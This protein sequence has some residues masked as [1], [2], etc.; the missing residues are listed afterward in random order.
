M[1]H[2]GAG[3]WTASK[4]CYKPACWRSMRMPLFRQR[5]QHAQH[6][7][8][9]ENRVHLN[10]RYMTLVQRGARGKKMLGWGQTLKGLKK[11]IT[12]NHRISHWSS[13]LCGTSQKMTMWNRNARENAGDHN[14]VRRP[15][16]VAH[17]AQDHNHKIWFPCK[18]A[19]IWSAD[20]MQFPQE[21]SKI[22]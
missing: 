16:R 15:P 11:T 1:F 13:S 9:T 22:T 8:D 3:I 6:H 18:S 5:E 12:F 10:F 4:G 21:W 14:S 20:W 2:R 17:T 7:R 19:V